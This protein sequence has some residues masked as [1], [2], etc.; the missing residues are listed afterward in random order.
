VGGV[1]IVLHDAD[2][3]QFGFLKPGQVIAVFGGFMKEPLMVAVHILPNVV[4]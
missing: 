3:I 2:V 1:E 4:A